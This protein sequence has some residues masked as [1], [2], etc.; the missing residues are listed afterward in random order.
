MNGPVVIIRLPAG[1]WEEFK[2]EALAVFRLVL[3]LAAC[4]IGLILATT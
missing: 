4:G 1:A 3:A 2:A